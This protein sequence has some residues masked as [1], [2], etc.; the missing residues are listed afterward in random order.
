MKPL[1]FASFLALVT[2]ECPILSCVE[3]DVEMD[4]L[5]F[6]ADRL[7]NGAIDIL[8][9]RTCPGTEICFILDGDYAWVNADL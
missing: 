4:N 7:P 3:N 2:A 1:I 8:K 5:C 6:K 9:M